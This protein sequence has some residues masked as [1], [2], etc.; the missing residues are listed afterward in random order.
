MRLATGAALALVVL[1]GCATGLRQRTEVMSFTADDGTWT[2]S[3]LMMIAQRAD[4]S[5]DSCGLGYAKSTLLNN[6]KTTIGGSFL[7]T[8]ASKTRTV[9]ELTVHCQIA[10]P[11]GS[12]SCATS[13]FSSFERQCQDVH[14]Y[15]RPISK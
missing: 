7:V 2:L 14:L 11:G 12:A 8:V 9:G 5:N 13:P 3:V 6:G 1:A 15:A 4:A 10:V